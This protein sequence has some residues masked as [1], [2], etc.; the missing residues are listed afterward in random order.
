MVLHLIAYEK[1]TEDYIKRINELFGKKN[2]TFLVFGTKSEHNIKNIEEDNVVYSTNFTNKIKCAVFMTKK[3]LYADKVIIHALFLSDIYLKLLLIL[4]PFVGEKYFWN[5]WGYD[6]YNAYWNRDKFTKR[7]RL[8]IKFIKKLK[9]VGYIYGDYKFLKEHYDTNAKFYIASY[10]YDFFT[11]EV[12]A[13]GDDNETVNILLGN[14]ATE[15]CR[16][17]EMI[18]LLAG[19]C[20]KSIKVKC[21]LSYPKENVEYRNRISKYGKE[22]LGDRFEALTDFTSFEEYT[23]LLSSIDIAIFNHNRQQ[24]LGNIASLLYLGKRVFINP[25]NACKGY[26]E[27]MGAKVFSTEDICEEDI[28]KCDESDLKKINRTVIDKFFSDKEFKSRWVKIFE[29]KY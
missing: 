1:F 22:K 2:H 3:I 4:Q 13:R 26:F 8:R 19:F 27:D 15:E 28:C 29:E 24:A 12:Y 23:K 9:A 16:Y 7:E 18:D 20:N 10:T 25:Q 17:E 14:S 5:I 6:L 21:V 11:P